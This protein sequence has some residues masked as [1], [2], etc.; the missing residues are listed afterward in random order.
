M[1]KAVPRARPASAL[2]DGVIVQSSS[3]FRAQLGLWNKRL[4]VI[5][6]AMV[7]SYKGTGVRKEVLRGWVTELRLLADA[8]EKRLGND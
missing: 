6:G 4:N 2:R 8:M 1:P 7:L 3:A 5:S